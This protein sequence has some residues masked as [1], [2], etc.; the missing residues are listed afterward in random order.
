MRRQKTA[1]VSD[2]SWDALVASLVGVMATGATYGAKDVIRLARRL[3]MTGV[4]GR[5]VLAA[6]EERGKVAYRAARWALVVNELPDS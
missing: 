3:G 4:L 5:Q 1:P 2:P 6:A